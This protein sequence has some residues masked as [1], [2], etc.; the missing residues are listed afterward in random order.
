M[1][2]L[3]VEGGVKKFTNFLGLFLQDRLLQ[4]QNVSNFPMLINN[5]GSFISKSTQYSSNK[6]MQNNL[7]SNE[8]NNCSVDYNEANEE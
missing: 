8:E 4:V 2:R 1:K 6:M 3:K 5:K 7:N